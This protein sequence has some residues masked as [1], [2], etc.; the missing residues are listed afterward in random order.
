MSAGWPQKE[1]IKVEDNDTHWKSSQIVRGH[2][3]ERKKSSIHAIVVIR[4]GRSRPA[5]HLS[6][7]GKLHRQS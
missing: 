6:A 2:R 5:A 1:S 4:V 7:V 3:D